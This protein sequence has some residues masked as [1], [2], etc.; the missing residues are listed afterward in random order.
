MDPVPSPSLDL[1]RVRYLG[2]SSERMA[3]V[4]SGEEYSYELPPGLNYPSLESLELELAP[5]RR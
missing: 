2:N 5:D 3:P 4:P 1:D